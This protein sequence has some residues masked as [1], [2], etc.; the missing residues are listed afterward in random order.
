[1]RFVREGLKDKDKEDKIRQVGA[2]LPRHAKSRIWF[3]FNTVQDAESKGKYLT[4]LG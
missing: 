4:D 3:R 2:A 1:M